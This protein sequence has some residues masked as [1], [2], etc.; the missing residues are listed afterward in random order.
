MAMSAS[1]RSLLV[2]GLAA[3][4]AAPRIAVAQDAWPGDRPIQII[5]P[6]PPGGGTD[7]NLRAMTSHFQR[8]LPGSRFVISNRGGAGGEIGYTAMATAAPDGY[9]IGTV[10]TPSLQ[11]ITIER[12]P[13]YRLEDFAYLGTI[14]EDPGGLHVA[15]DSP[16][17]SVGDL[18]AHARANPGAVAVGTA[19]IGSDDHLL[20][21]GLARAADIR[22]NHI[23]FAGQ[24]PTVTALIAGHIQV[25]SMN[26]GESVGLIRDG[27]VRPLASAGP[28]RFAMTPDV[29]TF[30]EAGYPLD[31]GVVRSLVAPAATPEP[32]RRRL[33]ET[34]AATMRDAAWI[35]EADKLFIPLQYRTPRETREIVFREAD[36]LRGVWQQQ[37]W[38]DS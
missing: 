5:V 21:I 28:R 38:R 1:R 13:R 14:V 11:T 16:W 9:T 24:A 4:L 20:M 31:T 2:A 12:Q 22:L 27:R 15:A 37:P 23:P 10:I 30:R 35:A 17:R 36:A 8:H 33:E 18:V 34:I 32:I 3:P 25:A 7:I 26:M 19:G 29:P 6:F